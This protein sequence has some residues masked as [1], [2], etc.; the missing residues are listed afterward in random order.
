[1]PRRSRR[2][3]LGKRE[4]FERGRREEELKELL[5]ELRR[6]QTER[7]RQVRE[8]GNNAVEPACDESGTGD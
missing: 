1:M 7:R 8:S 6:L 4:L 2:K 5:R 3:I